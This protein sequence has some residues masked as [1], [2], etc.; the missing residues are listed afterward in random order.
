MEESL[1]AACGWYEHAAA[2]AHPAAQTRLAHY[3]FGAASVSGSGATLA[4]DGV[5]AR[6]VSGCGPKPTASGRKLEGV[7]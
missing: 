4:L 1:A 2:Q 6:D 5:G 7:N 3:L